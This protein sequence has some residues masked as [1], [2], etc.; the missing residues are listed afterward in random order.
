ML[1]DSKQKQ[2]LLNLLKSLNLN[3]ENITSFPISNMKTIPLK[4]QT[5]EVLFKVGKDYLPL[6]IQEAIKLSGLEE[7]IITL[8]SNGM[9]YYHTKEVKKEKIWMPDINIKAQEVEGTILVIQEFSSK[10]KC[11]T[12][13]IKAEDIKNDSLNEFRDKNIVI[14]QKANRYLTKQSVNT[15]ANIATKL[16]KSSQLKTN[17]TIT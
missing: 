15:L 6:T 5:N 4:Y 2:E 10:N 12:M 1:L 16:W 11:K 14:L 17:Y 7:S 13:Y 9:H 3:I 8:E